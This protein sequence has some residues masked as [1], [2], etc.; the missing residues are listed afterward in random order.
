[1]AVD[2]SETVIAL[3]QAGRIF[4][5][6]RLILPLHQSIVDYDVGVFAE[7]DCGRLNQEVT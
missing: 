5:T 6:R 2:V 1:M 7:A 4:A 3:Y